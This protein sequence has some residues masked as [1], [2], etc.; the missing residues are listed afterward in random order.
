MRIQEY[1]TCAIQNIQVLIT[2]VSKPKKAAAARLLVVQRTV[3]KTPGSLRSNL[4]GQ[5][6]SSGTLTRAAKYQ[7]RFRQA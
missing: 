7:G 3:T 2:H 5:Q 1:L 6:L 4:C